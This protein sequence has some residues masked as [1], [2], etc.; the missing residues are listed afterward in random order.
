MRSETIRANCQISRDRNTVKFFFRAMVRPVMINTD[1]AK[2]GPDKDEAYLDR[3]KVTSIGKV[4][5]YCKGTDELPCHGLHR[6]GF[7]LEFLL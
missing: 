3:Q 5:K 1:V 7:V 4:Y 2:V 6:P